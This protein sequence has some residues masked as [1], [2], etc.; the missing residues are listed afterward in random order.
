M[1][2]Q[3]W[4]RFLSIFVI[5]YGSYVLVISELGIL[6]LGFHGCG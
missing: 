5:D 4:Y 6:I 3:I 2:D 1:K